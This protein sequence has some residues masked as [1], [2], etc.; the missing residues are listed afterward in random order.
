[1]TSDRSKG[2]F[3]IINSVNWDDVHR[4]LEAFQKAL[5]KGWTLNKEE[6]RGILKTRAMALALE[7]EKEEP[8]ERI[9]IVEFLLSSE[10]YGLELRNVREV[11]PLK[12]LTPIPCTP[13]FVL[14]VIN[15]RGQILSIIDLKKLLD[16]PE[17][18]LGDLNKVLILKSDTM[19]FGIL[20]DDIIGVRS[21]PLRELKQSVP[22]LTGLGQEYLKGVSKE[23]LIVL[24]A[25]RI[26]LDKRIVVEEEVR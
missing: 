5:E 1:M 10:R 7:F 22:T 17:K 21:V 18:G 3:S 15:V 2:S 11:W 23:R 6:K 12:D 13:P 4:R 8:G 19:E 16:L 20:A 24:D 26:L 9:E 25:G 14:G